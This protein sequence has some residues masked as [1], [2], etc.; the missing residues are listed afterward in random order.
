MTID[1]IKFLFFLIVLVFVGYSNRKSIINKHKGQ[2]NVMLFNLYL[3]GVLFLPLLLV[4]VL[5]FLFEAKGLMIV[6]KKT[7]Y[8]VVIT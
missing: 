1:D 8:F 3:N 6:S 4:A 2:Q 7:F 5:Y